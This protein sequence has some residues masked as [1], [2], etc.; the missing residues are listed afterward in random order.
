MPTALQL[1]SRS[2]RLI[3]ALGSGETPTADEQT[4]GIAA[5]NSMLKTWGVQANSIYSVQWDVFT[6]AANQSSRTYGS[7]GDLDA[8]RP[9]RVVGAFQRADGVDCPLR[10]LT[11]A[12]YAGINDKATTSNIISHLYFD[13]AHPLM[14]VYAHPVPSV[15]ASAH[16]RT[17]KLLQ[18]FAAATTELAMPDGYEDA[19]A[20]NL[21]IR[22]APE[23]QRATPEEVKR[24]AVTS[25][26]AIKLR[27]KRIPNSVNEAAYMASGRS[28]FSVYRGD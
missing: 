3:G 10:L 5:L 17:H 11:E 9:V 1:V 24:T 18:S 7:G 20:F 13:D 26:R 28:G 8:A 15:S 27:N 25:L 22:L 4:D 19:I 2:M 23:Y 12:Q 21:A 14:T 6:W 16:I